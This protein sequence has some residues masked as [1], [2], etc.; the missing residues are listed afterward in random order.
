VLEFS[1]ENDGTSKVVLDWGGGNSAKG[2]PV[3]R[4]SVAAQKA[5]INYVINNGPGMPESASVN[6]LNE[7]ID[8]LADQKVKQAK[9]QSEKA[10]ESAPKNKPAEDDDDV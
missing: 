7:L 8:H 2:N 10:A 1:M 5:C 4:M 3:L 6:N 9:K